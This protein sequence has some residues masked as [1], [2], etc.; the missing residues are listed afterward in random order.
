MRFGNMLC[1]LI[2]QIV[3][4]IHHRGYIICRCVNREIILS[5]FNGN[6]QPHKAAKCVAAVAWK[7]DLIN[8]RF[9]NVILRK[10]LNLR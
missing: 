7:Q 2:Q 1:Q 3:L 4:Y 9:S 6:W 10:V 5:A 8:T